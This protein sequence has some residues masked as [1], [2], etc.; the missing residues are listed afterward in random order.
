MVDYIFREKFIDLSDISFINHPT[1]HIKQVINP[2][3]KIIY[4]QNEHLK[5]LFNFLKDSNDDRILITGYSALPVTKEI[6]EN[7]PNCIKK[8]FAQNINYNHNDL[9]AIPLGII[10]KFITLLNDNSIKKTKK[11]KS[12]CLWND[13]TNKIRPK[14][15][16]QFAN[17]KDHIICN[18]MKPHEYFKILSESKYVISPPGYG[19]DCFRTWEALYLGAIP[20]VQKSIHTESFSDLPIVIVDD[21]TNINFSKIELSGNDIT[22]LEFSYWEKKIKDVTD[23][24]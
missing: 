15:K 12:C 8:W 13:R 2:K 18:R 22:K 24:I 20:I 16:L 5:D 4:C 7:K 10:P 1:T 17:K 6:F 19:I 21:I 11:Y 9:I 3:F 14:T 23:N